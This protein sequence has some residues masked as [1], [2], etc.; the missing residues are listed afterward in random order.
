MAAK[1]KY[2]VREGMRFGANNQYGPGDEV[3]LTPD[4]A[5]GFLDKLQP[6]KGG[7]VSEVEVKQEP[8]PEELAPA[9]PVEQAPTAK[10]RGG[11][12]KTAAGPSGAL[13]EEE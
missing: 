11:R 3:E 9:P 6:V 1:R 12:R 8:E 4:E 5:A 2:V 13:P 7:R 10:K